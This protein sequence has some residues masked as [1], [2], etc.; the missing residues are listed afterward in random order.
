M[1]TI[2]EEHVP[3]TAGSRHDATASPAGSCDPLNREIIQRSR[4]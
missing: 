2:V 3:F 1:N 4:E